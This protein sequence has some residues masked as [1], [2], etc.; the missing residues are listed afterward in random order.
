[1]DVESLQVLLKLVFLIAQKVHVPVAS[2][3]KYIYKSLPILHFPCLACT[4][5]KQGLSLSV[6]VVLFGCNMHGTL[7]L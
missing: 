7:R 4:L 5:L 6:A 1:M 3:D 2:A